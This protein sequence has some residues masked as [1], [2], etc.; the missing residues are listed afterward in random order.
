MAAGGHPA[1]AARPRSAIPTW[2]WKRDQT[3]SLRPGRR[4]RERPIGSATP[5]SMTL[6]AARPGATAR[7]WSPSAATSDRPAGA[8]RGAIDAWVPPAG[9]G[10]RAAVAVVGRIAA[11]DPTPAW[12]G[13]EW[14]KHS[15]WRRAAGLLPSRP[16]RPA[17]RPRAGR[18]GPAAVSPPPG[19]KAVPTSPR[20]R[21]GEPAT[22]ADLTPAP[23]SAAAAAAPET[24]SSAAAPVPAGRGRPESQPRGG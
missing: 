6:P 16:S 18:P 21:G 24:A 23:G 20:L 1:A 7:T 2:K 13:P 5:V 8:R 14:G 17:S 10:Q 19:A 11:S 9:P 15:R 12:R 3:P 4:L 22:A